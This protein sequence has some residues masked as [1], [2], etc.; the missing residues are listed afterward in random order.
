[1]T[2]ISASLVLFHAKPEVYVP[3]VRSFLDDAETGFLVVVDNSSSP[4]EHPIFADSRIQYIFNGR[5]VGFG[6]GHNIGIRACLGRSDFHLILN[7]DVEFGGHVLS[8]L[9]ALL[10][11]NSDIGVVMPR[12][13][14]PDGSLQQLCKM[15]PTPADLLFRRFIPFRS[16]VDGLNRRYELHGLPQD[17]PV[18]VP[19]LSGCFLLARTDLLE[20]VGGFDERYFMYMEDVDLVRRLG[21]LARTVYVPQV[22]VIHAYAKG[23]YVNR[24]LLGYHLK[25]AVKYFHKWGWFIDKTR[26]SRNRAAAAL[27]MGFDQNRVTEKQLS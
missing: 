25:S 22:A 24:R 4:T 3:A 18:D 20:K 13:L 14:Y 23:S 19:T 17:R 2:I 15:L 6:A 16:I 5:N 10:Q 1:M 12:I 9:A 27:C 26:R 21:D 11:A 7:P 8:S